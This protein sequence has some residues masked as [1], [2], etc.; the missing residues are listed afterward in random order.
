MTETAGCHITSCHETGTI[1]LA[2]RCANG[3]VM[4]DLFCAPHGANHGRLLCAGRLSCGQCF[5]MNP[6]FIRPLTEIMPEPAVS[7]P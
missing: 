3:H 7:A 6:D 5:S 2:G 4:D 1:R